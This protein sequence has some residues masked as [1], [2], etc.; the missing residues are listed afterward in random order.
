MDEKCFMTVQRGTGAKITSKDY[1][2]N[3]AVINNMR[4]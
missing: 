1:K 3:N 4:N 2:N